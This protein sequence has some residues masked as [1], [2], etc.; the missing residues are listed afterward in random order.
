MDRPAAICPPPV[1]VSS[2]VRRAAA[3]TGPLIKEHPHG[4]VSLKGPPH[5]LVELH[6]VSGHDE[7]LPGPL[8]AVR[9]N[10][11][12][13]RAL[14]HAVGGFEKPSQRDPD[15]AP[16]GRAGRGPYLEA[17]FTID[18]EHEPAEGQVPH[19]ASRPG[20]HGI[21]LGEH[22]APSSASAVPIRGAIVFSTPP[23]S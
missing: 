4:L 12:G 15:I 3:L 18:A 6:A 1:W 19:R 14:A 9:G 21:F 13:I 2:R 5:I 8:P 22:G 10:L 7:E 23:G 16:A 11:R 17:H 20:E